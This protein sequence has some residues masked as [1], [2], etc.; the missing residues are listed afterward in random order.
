VG[1]MR[2]V[3]TGTG[4]SMA[5]HDGHAFTGAGDA[6]QAL[7]GG[8]GSGGRNGPSNA[9]RTSASGPRMTSAMNIPGLTSALRRLLSTSEQ[10]STTVAP[11]QILLAT[12]PILLAAS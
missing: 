10:T 12:L 5:V 9:P 7:S 2:R 6:C 3:C 4:T 11:W 8:G 1:G